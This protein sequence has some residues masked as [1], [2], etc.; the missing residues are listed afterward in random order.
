[1]DR[2]IETKSFTDRYVATRKPPASGRDI[3]VDQTDAKLH[4]RLQLIV[5]SSGAKSWSIRYRPRNGKRARVGYG[6]YPSTTLD[7]ARQRMLEIATAADRGD[8]LPAQ[9]AEERQRTARDAETNRKAAELPQT[10]ADLLD[11]Y[12]SEYCKTNQRRWG[13]VERMFESH[14]K[15]TALGRKRLVEVDRPDIVELLDELQ[16]KKGLGAQVNRVRSQ[17]I[18]AFNWAVDRGKMKRNPAAG[19]KR[20]KIEN[21]RS[22]VLTD[23]ELRAIWRAA[24]GIGGP[25]G[26]L[27]KA[28]ALI[29]GRR[30]EVRC[31]RRTELDDNRALWLLPAARNKSKRDHLIPLPPIMLALLEALPRRGELVFS[32]NGE[33]PYAGQKRL[34]EILDRDSGVDKWTFHDFRRTASSGMARLGVPQDIIDRVLNHAKDTLSGT[35]NVYEYL[36]EKRCALE[37]WSDH[38]AFSVGERDRPG[39]RYPERLAARLGHNGGPPLDEMPMAQ[40]VEA[41]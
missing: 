11:L 24:D 1:M 26:P 15:D 37:T 31:L 39:M 8:D 19:V 36:D 10:V 3:Y 17:I 4:A 41:A 28:L 12:V 21:R 20:R 14:V 22:R 2:L 7:A 32:V 9:E 25:G 38:V 18:A 30:D 16:N 5:S 33:K 35:Y 29:A 6:L 34:K 23:D 40:I 13:L 27:T